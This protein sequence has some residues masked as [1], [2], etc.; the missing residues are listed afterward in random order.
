MLLLAAQRLDPTARANG[1]NDHPQAM[2]ATRPLPTPKASRAKFAQQILLFHLPVVLPSEQSWT[3]AL[4]VTQVLEILEPLPV[5][6]VPQTRQY[7]RG[8]LNWRTH[9]VTLIDLASWFGWK[10]DPND[11]NTRWMIVRT[12]H[13]S[14]LVAFP[15]RSQ[16]HALRLPVVH[17]PSQREW[18]F[19]RR[20]LR[21]L[22]ELE[23]KTIAIPDLNYILAAG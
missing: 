12:A 11:S 17:Q 3:F 10:P 18:P 9:P 21:A 19:D 13:A 4:S 16:V 5:L 22:F 6:P 2:A 14:E 23:N 20:S 8:L 7:V 1:E 15:V